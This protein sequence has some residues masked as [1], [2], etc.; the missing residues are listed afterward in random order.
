[1]KLFLFK[2]AQSSNLETSESLTME[3]R[4]EQRNEIPNEEMGEN[5]R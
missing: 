3:D 5:N 2:V 4:E 1:M